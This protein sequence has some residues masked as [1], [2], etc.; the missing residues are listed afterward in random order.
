MYDVY[1]HVIRNQVCFP[2][3]MVADDDNTINDTALRELQEEMGIRKDDVE[4]LG[5]LRCDWSEVA[6]YTGSLEIKSLVSY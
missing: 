1:Y 5:V 4:V 6:A 3:G 2:G